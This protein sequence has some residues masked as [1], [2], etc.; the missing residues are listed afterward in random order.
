MARGTLCKEVADSIR[1]D[2]IKGIWKPGDRLPGE[3]EFAEKYN[4]SRFT[5]RE[6]IKTLHSSGLISIRRGVGT[7]VS[8]NKPESYMRGLLSHMVLEP[9]DIKTICEARMPIESQTVALCAQKAD[10]DVVKTLWQ[11]CDSMNNK[12][13]DTRMDEYNRIDLAFHLYIAEI[14]GNPILYEML[15]A[16]QEFLIAQMNETIDP[17]LENASI[18]QHRQIVQA[19]EANDVE[20]ATLMMQ[21]HIEKSIQFAE[22]DALYK[23]S[24]EA[25]A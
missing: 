25:Q 17:R 10:K 6:A 2:I 15:S 16:L 1:Q 24:K 19:I 21:R 12:L 7:F 23:N 13:K 18:V 4:V 11:M 3:Y 20:L 9:Q 5:I 22:E 14:A 8:D